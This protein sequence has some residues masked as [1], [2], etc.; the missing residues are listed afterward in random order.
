MRDLRDDKQELQSARRALR[1]ALKFI[2]DIRFQRAKDASDLLHL[3]ER[4]E[5]IARRIQFEIEFLGHVAFERGQACSRPG[6]PG[7]FSF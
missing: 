2:E 1:E 5:D 7:D 6:E 3:D 4:I